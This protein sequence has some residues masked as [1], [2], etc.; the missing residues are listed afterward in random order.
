MN[1]IISRFRDN[2]VRSRVFTSTKDF[3]D[4]KSNYVCDPAHFMFWHQLLPATYYSLLEP[5]NAARKAY[6][7]ML[8][9][10]KA[11]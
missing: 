10:T 5:E 3:Y 6:L 1:T 4:L 9:R 2:R 8:L 11:Y 7:K